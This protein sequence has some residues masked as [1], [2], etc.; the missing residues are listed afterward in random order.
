MFIQSYRRRYKIEVLMLTV[1]LLVV[2]VVWKFFL[3]AE[4]ELISDKRIQVEVVSAA[5]NTSTN[6]AQVAG[7]LTV[8]TV[9]LPNGK[10]ATVSFQNSTPDVG[11][12]VKVRLQTFEDGNQR[13]S[14]AEL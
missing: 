13:V 11:D 2:A 12:T 3:P 9:Q 8:V 6:P 4:S 7:N 5:S 14:A 10:H 1:T